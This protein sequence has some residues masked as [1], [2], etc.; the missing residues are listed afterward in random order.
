MI[1]AGD[2]YIPTYVLDKYPNVKYLTVCEIDDRVTET[3]RKYFVIKDT[4]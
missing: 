3:V 2:M 4:V 1:G